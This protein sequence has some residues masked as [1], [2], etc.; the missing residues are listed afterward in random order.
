VTPLEHAVAYAT[1]PNLGKAVAPH[2]VLEVRTGTGKLVWRFDRDGP[3]PRQ[4]ITPHVAV[5]MIKM[6]NSVVENG[7]GRRAALDG[8]PTCGKTGTTNDFRDGWFV[9]YTG[10]FVGAVWMG[11]D[12]Y[13]PTKHM[14]GG[15]LPA[16][17]WHDIMAYAHQGVELRPLPG[18][19]PPQH[20]PALAGG[21]VKDIDEPH[22]ALLTH[23]ATEALVHLEDMFDDAQHALSAQSAPPATLGALDAGSGTGGA[24]STD[25]D[26]AN[27]SIAAMTDEN[28][29]PSLRGD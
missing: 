1:F 28:S 12:N 22:P 13:S 15:S 29:P 24:G 27:A 8:V 9:G 14:E 21:A 7:T 20:P 5:E 26:G 17:T 10:N 19:P 16:M 11:N 23:N 4:V 2:A 25:G 3:K 18:L 6:M